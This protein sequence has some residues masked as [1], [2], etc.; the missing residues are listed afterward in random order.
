VST[1][2]EE[3]LFEL[4]TI[5]VELDET[6]PDRVRLSFGGAVEF[7]RSNATQMQLFNALHAGTAHELVVSVHVAG[8]TCR[9]TRDAEG[10]PSDVVTT[11]R[12][13]VDE[14]Y[15]MEGEEQVA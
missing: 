4:P 15:A 8:D 5:R 7:D 14:V 9:H 13:V 11:K 6:Q 12:V 2:T 1:T 10:D 3:R